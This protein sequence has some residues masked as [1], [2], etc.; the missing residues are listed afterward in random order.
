M[1]KPRVFIS[2]TYY[3]LKHI[4]SSLDLFIDSM[5]FESVLSE[6][7]NIAY[8]PD[9]P[10]DESCYRETGLTDIFVLIIGGRYGSASSDQ[11]KKPS[12]NFFERY[13][14]ITRKEYEKANENDIPTY[15]LIESSVY[16]EYQTYLRN[17]NNKNI[18]YAHADSVNIFKLIENILALPK[19]NPIHTF[20]KATEIESWLRE[21]WAGLFRE[22]L[23]RMS[24]QKQLST[25]TGQVSEMKEINKTLRKYL[26]AVMTGISP[27][28]SSRL[29]ESEAERLRKIEQ[30]EE[31]ERTE[32]FDYAKRQANL[33]LDQFIAI[34]TKA[35]S[36]D[37]FTKK[38]SIMAKNKEAGRAIKETIEK[39]PDARR[40]FNKVRKI[41][42]LPSF[43][44]KQKKTSQQKDSPDNK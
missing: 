36:F 5:G 41:L 32:W 34:V 16:S 22:L 10:L 3:D 44:F 6:K 12:R 29:I 30:R 28:D 20:D 17:K 31:V 15:I 27:D 2:S 23:Q 9:T 35:K 26:E 39:Y 37:D 33:S 8:I 40:D 38:A 43:Q 21:Q 13:D 11:E 25:L 4:R 7:G 18:D 1:A 24:G 19:N 42:G 14:S